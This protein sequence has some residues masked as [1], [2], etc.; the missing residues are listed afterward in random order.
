[1]MK[2]LSAVIFLSVIALFLLSCDKLSGDLTRSEAK[3]I[4]LERNERVAITRQIPVQ[5]LIHTWQQTATPV[6]SKRLNPYI[7][8]YLD[9]IYGSKEEDFNIEQRR[10]LER[11][12]DAGYVQLSLHQ[13]VKYT[14]VPDMVPPDHRETQK[15]DYYFVGITPK[16]SPFLRNTASGEF[17]LIIADVVF[18]AIDGI[19]KAPMDESAR[20]VIYRTRIVENELA[21]FFPLE[22]NEIR[23]ENHSAYFRKYDNGWRL[24]R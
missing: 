4:L 17:E 1:M 13:E 19:T 18:D 10:F 16:L 15:A 2:K 5:L 8:Q 14:D 6:P 3:K 12:R 20:V 24:E 21:K 7:N 23:N 11:L 22:P 9:F